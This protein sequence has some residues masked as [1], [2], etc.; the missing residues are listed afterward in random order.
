L[1]CFDRIGDAVGCSEL[2][3]LIEAK[4]IDPRELIVG[5]KIGTTPY[6]DHLKKQGVKVCPGIKEAKE[7]AKKHLIAAGVRAE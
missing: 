2:I 7:E 5:G 1:N 4:D 6:G 3:R